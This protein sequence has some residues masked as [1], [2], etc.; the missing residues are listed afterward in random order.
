MEGIDGDEETRPDD[1]CMIAV[2]TTMVVVVVI[3]VVGEGDILYTAGRGMQLGQGGSGDVGLETGTLLKYE[4]CL[5]GSRVI[6]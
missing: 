6:I 4:K 2:T 5:A 1:E 3:V